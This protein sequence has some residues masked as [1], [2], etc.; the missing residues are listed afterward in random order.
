M[1][2]YVFYGDPSHAW[3]KVPRK[4][5]AELKIEKQ[6]THY[7]FIYGDYVYLEEDL[8]AYTFLAAA[9]INAWDLKIVEKYTDK[10]SKIRSYRSY[11]V[12]A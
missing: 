2:T 7:S 4:D 5:L 10:S 6:I 12:P 9:A 3:L 8:D 1:R 11:E